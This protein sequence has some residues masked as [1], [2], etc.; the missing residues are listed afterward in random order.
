MKM[1][2][3]D[4]KFLI[5]FLK[6]LSFQYFLAIQF[7]NREIFYIVFENGNEGIGIFS[8]MVEDYR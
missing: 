3:P 1:G 5:F 8:Y 7:R 4:D 6:I 2:W